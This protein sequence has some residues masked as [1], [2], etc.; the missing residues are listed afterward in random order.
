MEKLFG[1]RDVNKKAKGIFQYKNCQIEN[2]EDQK[3]KKNYFLIPK[4][5]KKN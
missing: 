3:I 5:M 4:K 2:S 1:A